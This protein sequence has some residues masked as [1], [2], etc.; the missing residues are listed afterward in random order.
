MESQFHISHAG[1]SNAESGSSNLSYVISYLRQ[2]PLCNYKLW[3]LLKFDD[4]C[5]MA[6]WSIGPWGLMPPASGIPADPQQRSGSIVIYSCGFPPHTT[7]P[8]P[9]TAR[10]ACPR[11]GGAPRRHGPPNVSHACAWCRRATRLGLGTPR[12]PSRPTDGHRH[13]TARDM[14]EFAPPPHPRLH[15]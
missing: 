12:H 6:G 11:V 4:S 8:P 9:E 1:E 5:T 13:N 10:F 14:G 3:R 15:C 7:A 2:T